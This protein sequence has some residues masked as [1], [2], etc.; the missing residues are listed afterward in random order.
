M[1]Y[2]TVLF[3][4]ISV[5][6][7]GQ[8]LQQGQKLWSASNP[9]EIANFKMKINDTENEALYS[10]FSMSYQVSGFSFLSKNFNQKILNIFLGEASWINETVL[11]NQ[12][13]QLAFQQLQFDL[14][15]V[16][17]RKF[18]KQALIEKKKVLK[19]FDHLQVISNKLMSEFSQER[20]LLIKETGSGR[21]TQK[22]SE[23][24]ERIQGKLNA[25]NEFRYENKK[26]IKIAR[27]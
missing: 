3:L 11:E 16:Y 26:K 10:Q 18:R 22:L 6:V 17:T 1:K 2:I 4:L 24:K 23:W 21:N 7:F 8:R 27:P 9:L 19:G 15:E 12:Q 25:L 13:A 14:S 5:S 20:A